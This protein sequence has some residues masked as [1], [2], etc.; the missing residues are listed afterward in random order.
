MPHLTLLSLLLPLCCDAFFFNTVPV[1][2]TTADQVVQFSLGKIMENYARHGDVD[3]RGFN[4]VNATKM[5]LSGDT[6]YGINMHV[7]SNRKDEICTINV[8]ERSGGKMEVEQGPFCMPFVSKKRAA[9]G[10]GV[11][12]NPADDDVMKALKFATSTFNTQSGNT[13]LSKPTGSGYTVNTQ[14]VSGLLYHFRSVTMAETTC[15]SSHT[16]DHVVDLASCTAATS[17][18]RQKCDFDVWFQSWMQPQY[19]MTHKDCSI[20]KS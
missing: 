11:P 13:F 12:V 5:A 19:Q 4:V 20:V 18:I 16:G 2:L 17:G 15:L 3:P 9:V 8:W 7:T 1:N 14:V 10:A 6:L